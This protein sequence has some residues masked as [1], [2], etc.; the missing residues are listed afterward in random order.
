MLIVKNWQVESNRWHEQ[1][2]VWRDDEYDYQLFSGSLEE[3]PKAL[4]IAKNAYRPPVVPEPIAE[5]TPSLYN[6]L[7]ADIEAAAKRVDEGRYELARA[8]LDLVTA[9]ALVDLAETMDCH[10]LDYVN[11]NFS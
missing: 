6:R 10:R 5:P 2:T 1:V 4:L 9:S 7:R 8:R 3:L 11:K